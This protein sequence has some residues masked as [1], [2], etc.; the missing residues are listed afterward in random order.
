M[1]SSAALLVV[2]SLCA[3]APPQE[4][5]FHHSFFTPPPIVFTA[6]WIGTLPPDISGTYEATFVTSARKL[7]RIRSHMNPG[8]FFPGTKTYIS[9]CNPVG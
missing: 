8:M 5:L 6:G 7:Y 9:L 1:S 4:V 3:P 2:A